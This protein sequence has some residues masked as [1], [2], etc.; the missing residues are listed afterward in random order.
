MTS[1]AR[2]NLTTGIVQEV[3][4]WDT[5]AQQFPKTQQTWVPCPDNTV[6]GASY[7]GGAVSNPSQTA[8]V[9]ST[10]GKAGIIM[11][12]TADE[13][14]RDNGNAAWSVGVVGDSVVI[15]RNGGGGWTNF[16][17]L[18]ADGSATFSGSV[19]CASLSASGAVTAGSVSAGSGA[20]SGALSAGS[21]STGSVSASGAVSGGSISAGSGSISGG[22]SVGSLSSSGNVS[23]PNVQPPPTIPVAGDVAAVSTAADLPTAIA[24]INAI[25]SSLKGAGLMS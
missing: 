23:A 6:P 8:R 22:L 20:I 15:Q 5:T 2:V 21:I 14:S 17:T 9:R 10:N 4:D 11:N 19:S 12:M 25:L 7:S 24:A 18:A 16:L 13:S 1:T 3:Q